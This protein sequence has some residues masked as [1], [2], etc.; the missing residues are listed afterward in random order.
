MA[1]KAD[2]TR[3]E[4]APY[5]CGKACWG[6]RL[7][8]LVMAPL[9]LVMLVPPGWHG[10][11]DISPHALRVALSQRPEQVMVVDVRTAT[12]F[13]RGHIEGALSVPLHLLPFRLST[14]A[15]YKDREVVL[16]CLSGHRSRV[17]GLIL[18]L[19]GFGTRTNLDGGMAA[20]QSG[21]LAV[22]QGG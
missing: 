5:P 1:D 19:A 21:G 7:L 10:M 2:T 16:I 14:L 13:K 4:N 15:P 3:D 12:E 11:G 20:W 22:T 6:G 18:S 8:L 17:A 9:L